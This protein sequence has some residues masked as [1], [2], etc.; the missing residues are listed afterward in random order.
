[1]ECSETFKTDEIL[2]VD[3]LQDLESNVDLAD[4]VKVIPRTLRMFC[5]ELDAGGGRSEILW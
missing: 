4:D 5:S 3:G 2:I 1:M